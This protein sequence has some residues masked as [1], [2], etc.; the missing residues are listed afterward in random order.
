MRIAYIPSTFLPIYSGAEIQSH[1]IANRLSEKNF[2]IEVWNSYIP[3]IKNNKYN[4][5]KFNNLF[6]NLIF[7]CNYYLNLNTKFFLKVYFKFLIKNNFYDVWHFQ[8]LNFKTLLYLDILI[9]LKQKTMVTFHGAD[10]QINKKINYGYRLDS[11]YDFLLRK[12]IKKVDVIQAISKTIYNDLIKLNV[13]KSKIVI[14]PNSIFTPKFK[15]RKKKNKKFSL[16]T[17]ARFAE[18]KKGF[19]FIKDI[20]NQLINIID[21]QWVFVGRGV[22]NLK[23]YDFVI[24][25]PKYFKLIEEIADNNEFYFPHSK[26]INLYK[27][28]DLYVHLSRIESFGVS[29]IEAM[30]SGLPILSF[31]SKGGEELVKNKING[32]KIESFNTKNFAKKIIF[33]AKLKKSFFNPLKIKNNIKVYDLDR[34][35]KKLTDCYK[36]LNTL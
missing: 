18:K 15:L 30:A 28:S 1:N 34:N 31:K 22:S 8:S 33:L 17:V 23:N 10:I 13:K 20:S 12:V 26:L 16:I 7:F 24:K 5:K 27:N 32:F 6:V 11:K 4:L 36:K 21:F 29:I 19:D 14:L 3:K 2:K 25:N 35:I 9:S